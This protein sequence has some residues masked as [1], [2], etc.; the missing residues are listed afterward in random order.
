MLVF[1]DDF[2]L[3][4]PNIPNQFLQKN[5]MFYLGSIGLVRIYV[6]LHLNQIQSINESQQTTELFYGN[7]GW[8]YHFMPYGVSDCDGIHRFY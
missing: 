8:R 6:C 3:N 2:Y 1:M 4:Q 7:M 5:S